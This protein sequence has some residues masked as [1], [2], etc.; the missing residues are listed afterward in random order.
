MPNL[1][2][3]DV[4]LD[5]DFAETLTV[6]RRT[7]TLVKGRAT[8]TSSTVS[9]APIGVVIPQS[10]VPMQRGPDQQHLP[11]LFQVHTPY[12]LRGPSKDP[13]TG[14][15]LPPDLII[16]NGDT[17][18]VNKVQD[19]SHFGPGFIQ[20]DCSSTDAIDNEPA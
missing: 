11:R 7:V 14:N 20:A 9:P 6:T 10:D 1:D 19:F 15:D 2:V 8:F 4:L 16:W 17:L 18:V 13:V 5:P 3:S 12:R